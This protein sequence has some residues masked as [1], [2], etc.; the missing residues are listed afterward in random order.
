MTTNCTIYPVIKTLENMFFN[1]RSADIW[2][3]FPEKSSVAI[4]SVFGNRLDCYIKQ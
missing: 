3:R 1:Q 2:N 4:W